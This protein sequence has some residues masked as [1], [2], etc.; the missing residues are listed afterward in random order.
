MPSRSKPSARQSTTS[1]PT[2]RDGAEQ[3]LALIEGLDADR[4]R[5]A[6]THASWAQSRADSYE[7]LEFLGDS[8]LGLAIAEE[9]YERFPEFA[10][11]RLAKIR[12]HV[13][14]RQ[15]C[16]LVGKRLGLGELFARNAGDVDPQEVKR[17]ATNRNVL[18]ALVEACLGVLYLEH[19]FEAIRGAVVAA[20][21]ERIDYALEGHVDYKTELQEELARR[22]H[23]VV[24][25][26]VEV[27]GPPH[28]RRFTCAA[29]VDGE[30]AGT[31]HGASKKAAEQAAAREALEA[32]GPAA[33]T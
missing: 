29:N 33:A 28:D 30:V 31:G 16:A 19:G 12:A 32:L 20:F 10:E 26:V 1:P 2:S 25:T 15:S 17:L 23:S 5:Q 14:S 18:A 6:F 11:G 21:R 24:Y 3:L 22:G 13:V 9:L 4:L 8:V 7:R 27:D